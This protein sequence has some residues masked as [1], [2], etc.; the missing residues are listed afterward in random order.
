MT[1]RTVILAP[2]AIER[3][4]EQ[5]LRLKRRHPYAAFATG[6]GRFYVD[7]D[8]DP[9]RNDWI[10][11]G[12]TQEECHERAEIWFEPIIAEELDHDDY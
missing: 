7:V 10:C 6:G 11:R 8:L 2:D 12:A 3:L 1:A 4:A 5:V 9:L